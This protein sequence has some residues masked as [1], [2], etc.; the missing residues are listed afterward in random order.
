MGR[1]VRAGQRLPAP[2][3]ECNG[4]E[5][6][7][8]MTSKWGTFVL[9]VFG[10]HPLMGKEMANLPSFLEIVPFIDG[11]RLD[12]KRGDIRLHRRSLNLHTAV[13]SRQIVWHTPSG[14]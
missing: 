2:L 11:E 12:M 6:F 14:G 8:E 9:G 10:Q 3:R 13:L 5:K 1:V 7:P 4:G